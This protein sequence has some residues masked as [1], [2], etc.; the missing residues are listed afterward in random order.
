MRAKPLSYKRQLF[1]SF[2]VAHG[3]SLIG[4]DQYHSWSDWTYDALKKMGKEVPAG[5]SRSSYS[6]TEAVENTLSV[7][8]DK[9]EQV[10][11]KIS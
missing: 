11:C 6:L 3:D 9:H 10:L 5:E 4:S 7:L 8:D 2:F 1:Q